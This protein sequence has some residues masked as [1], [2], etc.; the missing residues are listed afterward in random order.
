MNTKDT[1]ASGSVTWQSPSNIALIKYWGKTDPQIPKNVSISFTLSNCNTQT[2][3]KYRPK[4]SISED[5]DFKIFFDQKENQ[6]FRRKIE[7]FFERV[8]P[9]IPFIRNYEFE[10]HTGNSFPHSSGI[11]SSASGMSALALCLMSIQKS[12]DPHLSEIDFNQK[13][14]F[15]ARL[16]SGSAA[17][18]IEGPLVVWGQH[19]SIFKSS[20]LYGTK[21]SGEIHDVFTSFQ[22]TILLVD[23]GE[24]KV[25]STL[26]HKLM[27]GHPF[28][29]SRFE[30]AKDNMNRLIAILK[31]GELDSFIDIIEREA[32]SLHAMMMTSDPYFIL[33]KPNTLEIINRIWNFRELSGCHICFT[34]D[35]GANVHVLYPDKDKKAVRD[36]IDKEL[37]QFCQNGQFIHDNV[38]NGAKLL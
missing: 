1:G 20:N 17:R 22:D 21:Y 13:A 31:N 35:A 2:T 14:S 4:S 28:A 7:Q 26:G 36:F 15:L 19:H 30:Q 33:M 24:K 27:L 29:E 34:L 3:V 8:V 25:S 9:Y 32:L 16:G 6:S 10:I 18:S 12:M 37:V 38:G 11:A 23:K 5:F